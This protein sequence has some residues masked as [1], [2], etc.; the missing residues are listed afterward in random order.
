MSEV[1][2]QAIA[3]FDA[4]VRGSGGCNLEIS[5]KIDGKRRHRRRTNA[6][7]KRDRDER[8]TAALAL[9]A[10]IA[11]DAGLQFD[12]DWTREVTGSVDL[13]AAKAVVVG[14]DFREDFARSRLKLAFSFVDAPRAVSTALALG[15]VDPAVADAVRAH[16]LLFGVAIDGYGRRHVKLYPSFH[17]DGDDAS[18][19][20]DYASTHLGPEVV[21]LAGQCRRLFVTEGAPHEGAPLVVHFR[22]RDLDAFVEQG[23]FATTGARDEARRLR[24]DGLRPLV[25]SAALR[26]LQAQ[27]VRTCNLYAFED[28]AARSR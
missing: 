12:V 7:F 24:H 23:P 16:R 5:T 11:T 14:V 18:R 25:V 13:T 9:F 10:D 28:P 4:F 26:E 20:D 21:A 1:L 27:Q 6:W 8:I 2:Q 3:R 19:F 17:L 15:P 22:P